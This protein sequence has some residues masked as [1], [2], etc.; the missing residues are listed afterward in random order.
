VIQFDF[1]WEVVDLAIGDGSY[2]SFW[3][4]DTVD[5]KYALHG[6]LIADITKVGP[7]DVP[8]GYHWSY[9]SWGGWP[10]TAMEDL[11]LCVGL[12]DETVANAGRRIDYVHASCARDMRAA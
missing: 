3:P 9:G 11:A 4:A 6:A 5:E 12:S 8:A 1:A 7:D 10:M 2:F